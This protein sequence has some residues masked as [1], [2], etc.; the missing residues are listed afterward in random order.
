MTP[1]TQGPTDDS[2]LSAVEAVLPHLAT[3]E[4]VAIIPHLATKED[5]AKLETKIVETK[6]E[7][8]RWMVGTVVVATTI[9]G[10]ILRLTS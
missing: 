10:I 9:L 3:K 5:V 8:M 4:D 1:E 6:H 7:L 2:R